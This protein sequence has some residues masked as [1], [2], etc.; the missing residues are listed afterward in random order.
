MAGIINHLRVFIEEC[1][2]QILE[3]R[4]IQVELALQCAIRHP[5]AALEHGKGMVEEL[6]E[7][8]DGSFAAF[9]HRAPHARRH[10]AWA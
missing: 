7:C 1:F 5:P 10:T 3:R 2:L 8:H 4:I 6:L 9:A